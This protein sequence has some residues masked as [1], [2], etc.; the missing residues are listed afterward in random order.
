MYIPQSTNRLDGAYF[1][2]TLA[3]NFFQSYVKNIVLP[4]K[5]HYFEPTLF[6]FKIAGKRGSKYF[7]PEKGAITDTHDRQQRLTSE[8]NAGASRSDSA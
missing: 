6:G 5:V 3:H 2:S 1:G 7:E 8:M 4:P